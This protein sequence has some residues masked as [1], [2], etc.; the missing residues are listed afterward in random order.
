ME[1]RIGF[2][3]LSI[4]YRGAGSLGSGVSFFRIKIMGFFKSAQ[5]T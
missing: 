1:R 4:I 3:H 5:I 2:I